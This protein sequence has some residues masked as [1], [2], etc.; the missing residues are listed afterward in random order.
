VVS[1]NMKINGLTALVT[2][3]I[4]AWAAPLSRRCGDAG[5]TKSTPRRDDRGR[6][7]RRTVGCIKGTKR[8]G[9][10]TAIHILD[11]P[12]AVALDAPTNLHVARNCYEGVASGLK[13]LECNF[14]SSRRLT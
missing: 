3:A 2:G 11:V 7:A 6:R 14:F 10:A 1:R 5:C 13:A 12:A 8:S 9:E 4:A